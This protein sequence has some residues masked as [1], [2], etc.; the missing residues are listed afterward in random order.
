MCTRWRKEKRKRCNGKGM[1]FRNNRCLDK[2]TLK[3]HQKTT[4]AKCDFST[5][6]TVFL[7]L[8]EQTTGMDPTSITILIL[9]WKLSFYHCLH[10]QLLLL[11]AGQIWPTAAS[12]TRKSMVTLRGTALGWLADLNPNTAYSIMFYPAVT[13]LLLPDFNLENS[14]EKKKKNKKRLLL[15]FHSPSVFG[16][17]YATLLFQDF[18]WISVGNSF[19]ISGLRPFLL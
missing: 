4:T 10:C 16:C 19:D 3:A 18:S 1:V 14:A 8:G 11:P 2:T 5:E 7:W 9:T 6:S 13:D 17:V 12:R 15:P